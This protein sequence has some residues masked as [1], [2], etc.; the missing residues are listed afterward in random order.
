VE[1]LAAN[2]L[3]ALHGGTTVP[4]VAAGCRVARVPVHDGAPTTPALCG[5]STHCVLST[6]QRGLERH[7][8]SRPK[9]AAR[10]DLGVSAGRARPSS[11]ATWGADALLFSH[12]RSS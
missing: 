11:R 12:G 8:G 9:A 1:A 4:A 6:S 3:T 2:G 10:L 5:A 7:L